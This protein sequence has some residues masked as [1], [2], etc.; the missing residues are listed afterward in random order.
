MS[1][2]SLYTEFSRSQIADAVCDNPE[3]AMWLLDTLL[4]RLK[5]AELIEWIDNAE[6]S[7]ADIADRMFY[8]ASEINTSIGREA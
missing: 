4:H 5:P 7:P 2:F 1:D 6:R 8:I 3:Q